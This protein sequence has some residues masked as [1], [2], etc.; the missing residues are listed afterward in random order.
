MYI[1]VFMPIWFVSKCDTDSL[2]LEMLLP[3]ICTVFEERVVWL[4][5]VLKDLLKQV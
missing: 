2:A 3:I 1:V 5:I 4:A